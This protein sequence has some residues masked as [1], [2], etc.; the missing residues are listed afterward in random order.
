MT[1]YDSKPKVHS[2]GCSRVTEEEVLR[3]RQVP[4][5]GELFGRWLRSFNFVQREI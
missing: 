2:Y 1:W 4:D 3:S 5:E